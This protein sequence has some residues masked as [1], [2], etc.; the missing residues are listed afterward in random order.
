MP[1][2]IRQ[3]KQAYRQR[4]QKLTG[5]HRKVMEAMEA[6]I[7]TSELKK[8]EVF[9][10]CHKL[11]EKLYRAQRLGQSLEQA[12]GKDLVGVCDVYI[13]LGTKKSQMESKL[14]SL[15]GCLMGLLVLVV[16]EL[17]FTGTIRGLI[18]FSIHMPLTQG[19]IVSSLLILAFAWG[20]S[21]MLNQKTFGFKDK[22]LRWRSIGVIVLCTAIWILILFAKWALRKNVLCWVNA[23]I[24]IGAVIIMIGIALAIQKKLA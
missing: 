8:S 9:S 7:K 17:F 20:L 5:E 13:H 15:Q 2:T 14:E 3:E 11:A 1:S 12:L 4:L 24:P 18:D 23:W 22:K 6:Y 16:I 21:Q 10:V 19:F